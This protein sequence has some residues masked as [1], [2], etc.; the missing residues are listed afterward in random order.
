MSNKQSYEGSSI[1]VYFDAS[2]CIHSGR[3]VKGVPD[4]FRAGAEGPWIFPDAASADDIAALCNTCP[5]GALSFHR[6]DGGAEEASPEINTIS[7][8]A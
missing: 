6:T 2:R 3:C 1:T 7:V 4:V 5:S 8:E